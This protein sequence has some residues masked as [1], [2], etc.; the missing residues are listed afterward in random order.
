MSFKDIKGQNS[1][2]GFLKNSSVNGR[3]SHAYIFLGPSG[4]GRK[5]T[6]LNFAKFL[7]CHAPDDN[8]PCDECPSCRKVDSRNHP[9]IFLVS[10][11]KAGAS[12]GIDKIRAVIKNVGLKPYEARTKVYIIDDS[13]SMT[14]EAQNAFLKTLEEPPS[15]SVLIFISDKQGGLLPTIESRSQ[16]VKFFPIDAD[17]VK[18]ILK[19]NYKLDDAK[20]QMLSRISAGSIDAALRYKDEKFFKKRSQVL[21]G[22]TDGSLFD[23]DFEGL[24]KPDLRS[25]LDIMLT[26]YRD[27]LVTKADPT[28]KSL[29]VNADR[30]RIIE[31][32][33]LRMD[34]AFLDKAIKQV[35]LTGQFLD[36]NINPKLA[37]STLGACICTK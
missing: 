19:N 13:S 20:A 32:E 37:M 2:I 18:E 25:Y 9:D 34:F 10:P 29:L 7:N 33:A 35:I 4:V 28:L 24:S 31:E 27:I 5:L 15:D 3:T 16:V 12:I 11:E 23:S 6:A 14:Q 22:I 21:D 36:Q 30:T 1:A 8:R 26:W 17:T